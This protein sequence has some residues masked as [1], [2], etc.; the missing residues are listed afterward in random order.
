MR[1]KNSNDWR[2]TLLCGLFSSPKFKEEEANEFAVH[3]MPVN[4]GINV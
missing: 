1:F 2:S 3:I 4:K